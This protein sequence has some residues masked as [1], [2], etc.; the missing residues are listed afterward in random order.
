MNFPGEEVETP[1]DSN[2]PSSSKATSSRNTSQRTKEQGKK[3]E[4]DENDDDKEERSDDDASFQADEASMVLRKNPN[5]EGPRERREQLLQGQ[6]VPPHDYGR[7]IKK[8]R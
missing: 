7:K 4:S 5:K 1:A 6:K 3:D 2:L 8:W